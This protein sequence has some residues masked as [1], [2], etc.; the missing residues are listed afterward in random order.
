MR[1]FRVRSSNLSTDVPWLKE[2]GIYG[3]D[4]ASMKTGTVLLHSP[5]VTPPR[6]IPFPLGGLEEVKPGKE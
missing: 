1:R 3:G 6:V 4:I 5:D 2:G